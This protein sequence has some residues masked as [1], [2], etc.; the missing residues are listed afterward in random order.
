MPFAL[1][2]FSLPAFQGEKMKKHNPGLPFLQLLSVFPRSLSGNSVPPWPLSVSL[3]SQSMSSGSQV[4]PQQAT[5]CFRFWRMFNY[6]HMS[7]KSLQCLILGLGIWNISHRTISGGKKQISIF[8]LKQTGSLQNMNT[9]LQLKNKMDKITLR[10]YSKEKLLLKVLLAEHFCIS[11]ITWCPQESLNQTWV[12]VKK[13]GMAGDEAI[14][15]QLLETV[16]WCLGN[17]HY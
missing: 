14:I 2:L 4:K 15:I 16:Y 17:S 11:L 1:L 5:E 12:T 9:V 13:P 10:K 6:M 7:F 3:T 8:G